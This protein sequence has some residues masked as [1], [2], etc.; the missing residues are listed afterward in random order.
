[1]SIII[2]TT[3]VKIDPTMRELVLSQCNARLG[4]MRI[5]TPPGVL[6]W[7]WQLGG[8]SLGMMVLGLFQW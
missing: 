1:M 2:K 6:P 3:F 8:H 4:V 5:C 7:Y